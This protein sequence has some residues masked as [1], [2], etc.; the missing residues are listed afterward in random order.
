MRHPHRFVGFST[1]AASPLIN[2]HD[3]HVEPE[4]RRQGVARLLLEAVEARARA[5]GCSS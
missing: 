1:F 2:I 5:L 4:W 3:L